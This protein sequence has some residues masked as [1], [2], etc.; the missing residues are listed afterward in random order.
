MIEIPVLDGENLESF[1]AQTE[2]LLPDEKGFACWVWTGKALGKTD[3]YG[4]FYGKNGVKGFVTQ[5]AWV[6]FVGPIPEVL[7]T[8]PK[9]GVQKIKRLT[10]DH[11]CF[12]TRC[13]NPTHL[14]P[15]TQAEN[16]LAQRP[17][18]PRKVRERCRAGHRYTEETTRYS[19]LGFRYCGTCEDFKRGV[20]TL[21]EFIRRATV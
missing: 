9:T 10:L 13:W 1:L 16:V 5:I 3:D 11:L 7:V 12:R 17:R 4:F 18:K 21:E 14:E 8:D 2:V 19:K 6:T 20:I 15:K